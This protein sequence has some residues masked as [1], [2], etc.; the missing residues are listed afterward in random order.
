MSKIDWSKIPD[1]FE[2]LGTTKEE[3]LK[4]NHEELVDFMESKGFPRE[5]FEITD[6][7]LENDPQLPK[8]SY[9]DEC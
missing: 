3:F 6:E 8:N 7:D 1:T 4:M 5:W 2:E 9:P